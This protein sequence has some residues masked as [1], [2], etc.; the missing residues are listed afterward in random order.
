MDIDDP[1]GKFVE[2]R[3]RDR[4]DK[5]HIIRIDG[6]RVMTFEIW[7]FMIAPP[8]NKLHEMWY[9]SLKQS[10]WHRCQVA[11]TLVDFRVFEGQGAPYVVLIKLR[12][13]WWEVN[14][15]EKTEEGMLAACS[16]QTE[17]LTICSNVRKTTK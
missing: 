12:K 13:F 16:P 15:T 10:W 6:T 4:S 1:R 2:Q 17:T 9:A 5:F 7:D 11:V 3:Q 8:F 14:D